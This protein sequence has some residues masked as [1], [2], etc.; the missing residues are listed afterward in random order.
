MIK[1]VQENLA[2]YIHRPRRVLFD[3]LPKCAGTTIIEFLLK[4]YPRRLVYNTNYLQHAES[5]NKFKSLSKKSRYRYHLIVGHLT[6]DLLDYVHPDT[7]K[8][9]IFRDPVDRVISYYFFVKQQKQ[10]YLHDRVVKSNMRLEDF[11][12]SFLSVEMRNWYTTHFTGLSIE[13]AESNPKES[14]RRAVKIIS[15]KYGIIG[16]QDDLPAVTNKLITSAHL[17]KKFDNQVLNKTRKRIEIEEV[18]EN[19]KKTIT[20]VNFL[21]IKLYAL[22]KTDEGEPGGKA[23]KNMREI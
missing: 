18:P 13:Q 10:H 6:N 20:E 1:S 22:L 16:F 12:S 2:Y 21:D 4:Q 8:M 5:V 19:T 7:I 11:A 9:T 17:Y 23:D 15:K 3:H 14:L